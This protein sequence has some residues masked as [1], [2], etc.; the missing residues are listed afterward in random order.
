MSPAR[1]VRERSTRSATAQQPDGP[2]RTPNLLAIGIP[3]KIVIAF[4]TQ[5][6]ARGC[7]EEGVSA[8]NAATS[9]ICSRSSCSNPIPPSLASEQICLGHF[10]D[11]AFLRTTETMKLCREGRP[12]G[13]K[14]LERLLSDAIAIVGNLE[15]DSNGSDTENRDRMFELLLSLANLHEYA[16]N[17]SVRRS[18]S[19]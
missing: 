6:I 10:L 13:P 14:N 18:S 16:A 17:H 5:G 9:E 1:A 7:L 19:L 11:E 2:P 3:G 12:I 15:E 8:M 4:H